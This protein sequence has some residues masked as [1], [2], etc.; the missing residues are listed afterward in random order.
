MPHETFS[1]EL[2]FVEDVIQRVWWALSTSGYVIDALLWDDV[3]LV[4]PNFQFLRA[5]SYNITPS[6]LRAE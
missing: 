4:L 2:E 1:Q 6:S 3:G 5:Q